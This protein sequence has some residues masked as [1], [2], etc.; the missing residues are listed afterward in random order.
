MVVSFV[1]LDF[2]C[3]SSGCALWLCFVFVR[4]GSVLWLCLWLCVC[5]CICGCVCDC[6]LVIVCLWMC[7]WLCV[8]DCVFGFVVV[9]VCL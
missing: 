3:G 4:C 5:D 8:C 1:A 2:A 6:V 7:L 9:I